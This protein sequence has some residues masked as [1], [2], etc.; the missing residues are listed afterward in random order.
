AHGNS[1]SGGAVGIEIGDD[2]YLL[3]CFER[4]T[5]NVHPTRY[6]RKAAVAKQALE[7]QVEIG[8]RPDPSR[9]E[10]TPE[11]RVKLMGQAIVPAWRAADD[12]LPHAQG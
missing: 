4:A 7:R 1:A 6:A 3:L 2:Q 5:E 9:G 12:C 11:N 8:S 10:H